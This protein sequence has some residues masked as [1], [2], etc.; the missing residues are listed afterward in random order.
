M[1]T[2]W[3]TLSVLLSLLSIPLAAQSTP[4]NIGVVDVAKVFDDYYKVKEAKARMA[5]SQKIFKEEMEIF[6]KELKKLVDEFNEIQTKLKNPN[7]DSETL[8][9]QAQ[10]KLKV[11]RL[12]ESDVKQY[13]ERYRGTLRQREKNLLSQ[14]TTDIRSAIAKVAASKQLDLVLSSA[15]QQF[16][17]YAKPV[18]DI[19]ADVTAV[20]N[21]SAPK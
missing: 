3:I 8:R 9:K 16:V 2:S 7:L 6:Q 19:T 4:R 11:I 14:H 10:A 1:N 18:F 5:K 20:I 15:G 17:L 13:Q 21:A 12:K